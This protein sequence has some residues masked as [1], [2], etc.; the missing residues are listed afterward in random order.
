MQDLSTFFGI[1]PEQSRQMSQNMQQGASALQGMIGSISSLLDSVTWEGPG[2]K[3][4]LGDWNGSMRPETWWWRWLNGPSVLSSLPSTMRSRLRIG[5]RPSVWCAT[6]AARY[7]AVLGSQLWRSSGR[8]AR[9][10]E[11][12][13]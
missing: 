12:G 10:R 2:A 1:D 9:R 3:S 5:Q 4:F 11:A 6:F 13:Q 8:C 7:P